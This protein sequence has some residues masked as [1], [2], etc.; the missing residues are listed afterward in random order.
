MRDSRVHVP[1]L[2]GVMVF[3]GFVGLFLFAAVTRGTWLGGMGMTLGG[4]LYQVLEEVSGTLG[5]TRS[6]E[7]LLG[8]PLVGW[9]LLCSLLF[10]A[11]AWI[12]AE[13]IR[14]AYLKGRPPSGER[15]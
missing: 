2:V 15:G 3:L 8:W 10:G 6:Y 4:L 12:L 9:L 7:V 5:F 11:A 14:S 1:Y 13:G